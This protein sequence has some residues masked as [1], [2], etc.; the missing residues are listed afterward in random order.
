M[1][2]PITFL[3]TAAALVSWFLYRY[4]EPAGQRLQ[5]L[6]FSALGSYLLTVLLSGAGAGQMLWALFR[7][8]SVL[9]AVGAAAMASAHK[10]SWFIAGSIALS[11]GLLGYAGMVMPQ[12]LFTTV[13]MPAYDAEAELLLELGEGADAAALDAI[14]FK[15]GLSFSPAFAPQ[16]AAVTELDDYLAV[17]IPRGQLHKIEDIIEGL[18][19][20]PEVDW[21]EPNEVVQIAPLPG[22]QR[23]SPRQV[24]GVDDPGLEQQWGFDAM[25]VNE[26]YELLRKDAPKAKQ[27]ALI[28]ILDTGVDAAHEDL[29]GQYRSLDPADDNDPRG[30]G[31][32]CAGIAAAVTDNGLGVA[33]FSLG[34]QYVAVTSVKVLN[35]AGMGTQRSIIAGMI[36]AADAGADVISMSLGGPSSQA[37]ERAYRKAVD[38]ALESGAIIVVAAGNSN[39]DARKFVPA[40]LP[41]VITVSAIGPNLD[42]AVFSNEVSGLSRGIAAPGVDIYSTVPNNNYASYNGTSMAT[43]YVAG[44]LGLLKSLEPDLGHEEAYELLKSTGKETRQTKETG[45]LIQPAAAVKK[46]I[47]AQQ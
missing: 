18:Q 11:A 15:Y 28:A 42:R 9:A 36:K 17:D 29:E 14:A 46:L 24:Y 41:G 45:R 12:S 34:G 3:A 2:Y 21:V 22:G 20:I 32:H 33:S 19:S 25:A 6:F 7:D 23:K 47:S 44:L 39:R 5:Y 4:R 16:H 35:A 27:T 43:P 1:I 38:Y 13:Q 26:L 31:T 30:H 37:K 40:N 10:R 8:F